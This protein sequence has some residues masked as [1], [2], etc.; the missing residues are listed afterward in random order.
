MYTST[1]EHVQTAETR[2]REKK[3]T[4]KPPFQRNPT[5]YTTSVK[6]NGCSCKLDPNEE[7]NPTPTSSS[8]AIWLLC[9]PKCQYIS[10][11]SS[12]RGTK[13]IFWA[14]ASC[15]RCISLSRNAQ[16]NPILSFVKTLNRS[17][18]LGGLFCTKF[19][20]QFLRDIVAEWRE[21]GH[22]PATVARKTVL[23]P[24]ARVREPPWQK[25]GRVQEVF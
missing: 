2:E 6:T 22:S 12:A 21:T 11:A 20:H 13:M 9:S 10:F 4:W 14:S 15:C 25:D 18:L 17:W 24:A 8:A 3:S 23:P 16:S 19:T 7:T 1:Y 5:L